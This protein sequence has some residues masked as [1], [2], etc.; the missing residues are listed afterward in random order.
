L[1]KRQ[2]RLRGIIMQSTRKWWVL[3]ASVAVLLMANAAVQAC[4]SEQALKTL[5]DKEMQ[6]MLQRIPPAFADAV[7]DQQI[8]GNMSLVSTQ[9]CLVHWQL[10]LPA[11][12]IAEAQALLQADPAKQI[13]LAAQGYQI[14]EAA[15][16]GADFTVDMPHL[17]PLHSE[18]LQ[19]A[20][21]GKLRASVELMYAML[22][23]AR[24]DALSTPAPWSSQDQ[25][26]L[27]QACHQ[28][29]PNEQMTQACTCY[30]QGLAEKYSYRQ[31]RYNQYLSTNPY[32]FA[33]GN[34]A[35]YKRLEKSLQATCGLPA[36]S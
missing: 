27:V 1:L 9:P 14:P 24:A 2:N 16:N 6:Y 11:A 29:Y 7:A 20:P 4:L 10:Q 33:T 8:V 23:Q 15:E 26:S 22:T 19:T 18:T 36:H 5:A 25:Q 21:L 35:A 28:R 3:A 31:V 30:A 17:Q 13:M 32:A 34:G 12:E